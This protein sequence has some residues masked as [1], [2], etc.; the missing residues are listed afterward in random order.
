MW[1]EVPVLFEKD[2]QP[3]YADLGITNVGAELEEINV[4]MNIN[5]IEAFNSN[6]HEGQS[7][8][9]TGELAYRVN[10]AYEDLKTLIL[11]TNG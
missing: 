5:H 3:N 4:M 6:S 7:T 9:H 2:G 1:I 11:N 10:M 8:I